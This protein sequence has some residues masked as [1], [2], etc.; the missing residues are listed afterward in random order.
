MATR[1]YKS[2]KQLSKKHGKKSKNH[3][4]QVKKTRKYRKKRGG[5]S[6][7]D[8]KVTE[9]YQKLQVT[10]EVPHY[11][12]TMDLLDK[13]EN[14]INQGTL[15]KKDPNFFDKTNLEMLESTVNSK[16]VENTGVSCSNSMFGR[17]AGCDHTKE[18]IYKNIIDKIDCISRPLK[19]DHMK[20]MNQIK[21]TFT[22]KYEN[23]QAHANK[24][25]RK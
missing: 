9:K 17:K 10:T 15:D 4:K 1:K 5:D 18:E 25:E 2:K 11:K 14:D 22:Q 7:C 3:K 6:T 8:D 12:N 21:N 16:L 24:L 23:H 19:D 13:I 20:I